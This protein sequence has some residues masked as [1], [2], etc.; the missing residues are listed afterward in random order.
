MSA[1]QPQDAEALV[2]P[3]LTHGLLDAGLLKQ[4]FADLASCAQV[5]EVTAKAGTRRMTTAAAGGGRLSL[6]EALALLANRSVRGVQVRYRY[7]GAEWC[8]TLL[9]ADGGGWRVV[10]MRV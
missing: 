5:L 10:R 3:E 6:D 1:S 7:D 2:L 8:D 4:L 9:C